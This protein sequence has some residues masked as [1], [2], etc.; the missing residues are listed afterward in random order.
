MDKLWQRAQTCKKIDDEHFNIMPNFLYFLSRYMYL[1]GIERTT[2]FT[3]VQI[4]ICV[5]VAEQ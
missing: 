3:T 1:L 4:C 5:K 2:S